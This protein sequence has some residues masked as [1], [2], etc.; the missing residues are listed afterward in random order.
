MRESVRPHSV[1]NSERGRDEGPGKATWGKLRILIAGAALAILAVRASAEEVR[2]GLFSVS[3]PVIAILNDE[4]FVGE[5]VGYLDRTGTIELRSV[6]DD[7]DKCAGRFRFT[8]LRVGVA[9]VRCDDGVEATLT[10]NALGLFSGY[11]IGNTLRGP[12]SF[13]FG[14]SPE[15]ATGHLT[16]PR[17]KKLIRATD[18]LKLESVRP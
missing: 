1:C 3:L 16:L 13:T 11:G 18:G 5:A 12:A 8:G 4:L 17:G 9:D 14:L 2:M 6:R 15:E 10:F 7:R